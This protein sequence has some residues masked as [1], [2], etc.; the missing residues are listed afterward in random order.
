MNDTTTA[1][2]AP[3]ADDSA[4]GTAVAAT[5]PRSQL[6]T[7]AGVLPI[8]PTNVNEA[9]QYARGLIAAG[10]VPDA[11]RW[12]KKDAEKAGNRD[13]EGSP[14]EP[15]I[16]MGVLKCLEIGVPPQ[17]GLAGLLPMNGR[18]TVWGDLATALAQEKGLVKS[19]KK[20]RIGTQFDRDNTPIG[21]WP[22]DYGWRVSFWRVGQEEPYVQEYTVGDAKRATLWMNSYKKPWIQHPDRMLFN[23]AR[24]FALR[25][26]FADGLNGL[27]IAEEVID[28]QPEER[29]DDAAPKSKRLSSLIDEDAPADA[30]NNQGVENNA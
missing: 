22:V 28:L 13:L 3:P 26:G 2:E 1:P 9:T 8:L 16:I 30:G 21:E 18:F 19:Q 7:Q 25:D 11:F 15:L 6:T 20:E 4:T 27:A 24:A 17:T 12:S 10:I 29:P 23:R 14:N 5:K